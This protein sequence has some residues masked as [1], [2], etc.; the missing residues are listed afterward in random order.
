MRALIHFS[1][2]QLFATQWTIA[3]QAPLSTGF[4]RQE[5]WNGL[6]CPPPGHLSNP[7][8][9][10]VSLPPHTLAGRFFTISTTLPKSLSLRLKLVQAEY[11]LQT[12]SRKKVDKFAIHY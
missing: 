8:I 3:H 2:V 7:G 6:P 12:W 1:S 5:Y 11:W 9:K 10:S 4:S